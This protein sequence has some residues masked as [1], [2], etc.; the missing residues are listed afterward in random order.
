MKKRKLSK[1]LSIQKLTIS[2]LNNAAAIVGGTGFCGDTE[3]CLSNG[4]PFT[5]PPIRSEN[6]YTC[7]SDPNGAGC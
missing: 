6:G 7:A 4:D 2:K 5:C 3:D 1:K